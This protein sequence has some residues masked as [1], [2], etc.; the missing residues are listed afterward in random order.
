MCN[1]LRNASQIGLSCSKV[2]CKDKV[3][4]KGCPV[5]GI[6]EKKSMG[7]ELGFWPLVRPRRQF[8]TLKTSEIYQSYYLHIAVISDF[9]VGCIVQH[10]FLVHDHVS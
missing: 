5:N 6:V 7:G 3:R 9:P 8:E 1:T 10:F 4:M 2:M